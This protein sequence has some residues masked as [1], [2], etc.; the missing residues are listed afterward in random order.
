MGN[1]LVFFW[2]RDFENAEKMNTKE[3][4]LLYHFS[5]SVKEIL[6]LVTLK[7]AGDANPVLSHANVQH[8]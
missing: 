6:D 3:E 4:A 1:D 5:E 8:S 2:G 7:N